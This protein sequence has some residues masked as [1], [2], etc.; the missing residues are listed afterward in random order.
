MPEELSVTDVM[1]KDLREQEVILVT[2]VV[3]VAEGVMEVEV[4]A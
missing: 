2:V 1:R 4:V 3:E